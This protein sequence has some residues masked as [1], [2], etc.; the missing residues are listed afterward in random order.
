[1]KIQSNSI[2]PIIARHMAVVSKE[3]NRLILSSG[4]TSKV[5]SHSFTNPQI[6]N[7]HVSYSPHGNPAED[8][9][10]FS[11]NLTIK[12]EYCVFFECDICRSTGEILSEITGYQ[13]ESDSEENL[14]A[15]VDQ[16]SQESVKRILAYLIEMEI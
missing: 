11:I 4:A 10:D 3:L 12:S 7:T 15:K 9:I 13:I 8:S 14:L 6:I 16:L 5:F 2:E 1:M